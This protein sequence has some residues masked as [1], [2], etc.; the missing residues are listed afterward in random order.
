MDLGIRVIYQHLNVLGHLTVGENLSLGREKNK[1][2]FIDKKFDKEQSKAILDKIGVEINSTTLAQNLSIAERQ[3]IEIGRALQGEIKLIVMDEP[4]S[5]LG[6]QEVE[7]LFG[8]IRGLKDKGVAIVYISHKLEEV[9]NLS[10]RITV[11]RD[12]QWIG[13]VEAESTSEQ[14]LIE[15]MVG[16]KLGHEIKR[17]PH[18][19][20]E[21]VLEVNRLS[22]TSGLK[23]ISFNLHKGEILGVY[24]LMGSGRTELARA[25]F[26]ADPFASGEIKVNGKRVVIKSPSDAKNN[27][28]GLV[29]EDK[30]ESLFSLISVRENLTNASSDLYSKFNFVNKFTERSLSKKMIERL[31]I[32]TSSMEEPV[33]RLSG[34]NQQK[35]LIG[36]WLM[37]E[38]QILILDDPT[39]G[40][41]VG[42]KQELYKLMNQMTALNSSI[43]MTSSELPELMA[44][45]DRILVLHEGAIAGIL[46]GNEI[47]QRNILNLAIRSGKDSNKKQP[48]FNRKCIQHSNFVFALTRETFNKKNIIFVNDKRAMGIFY[49]TNIKKERIMRC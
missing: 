7:R 27:G 24:G 31:F 36:R 49:S 10:D 11:L 2:G 20:K 39:C 9:M 41:D 46:E 22:S 38:S 4:T 34:G 40:I 42:V 14:D 26:G 17:D 28:I 44:I 45:S 43:I 35:V 18:F 48:K 15:M 21:V 37:R 32:R 25:L 19:S 33:A 30:S 5:S 47:N 29:S 23:N 13:T 16:R 6:D 3:L 12:G 8:I 1:Y